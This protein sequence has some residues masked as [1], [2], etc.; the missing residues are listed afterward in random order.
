MQSTCL[1][2]DIANV[3][4]NVKPSVSVSYSGAVLYSD[5]LQ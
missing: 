5:L 1:A 2:L 3:S 4:P